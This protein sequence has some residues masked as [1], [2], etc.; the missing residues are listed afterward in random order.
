MELQYCLKFIKKIVLTDLAV[1]KGLTTSFSFHLEAAQS[2]PS[3]TLFLK[4]PK[5]FKENTRHCFLLHSLIE[6]ILVWE[7]E[8]V[9][10]WDGNIAYK[11]L[12]EGWTLQ[13]L[14]FA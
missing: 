12:K 9:N 1:I 11:L 7:A 2:K 13:S 3:E 4:R 10:V 5:S 8:F 6:N 14:G